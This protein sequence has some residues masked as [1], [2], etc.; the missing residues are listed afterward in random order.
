MGVLPNVH[1]FANK[2]TANIEG[3]ENISE[4]L[5]PLRNLS[6][7]TSNIKIFEHCPDKGI[8]DCSCNY[9]SK[10]GLTISHNPAIKKEVQNL[11]SQTQHLDSSSSEHDTDIEQLDQDFSEETRNI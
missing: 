5:T 8:N 11:P 1:S 3:K 10:L 9:C 6:K 4:N 7:Q 2:I